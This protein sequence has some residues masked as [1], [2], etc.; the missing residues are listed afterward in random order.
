[1]AA[2][3][4]TFVDTNVLVYAHD[5]SE[6]VKQPLA[7]ALLEELWTTRTGALSTQVLQEFYVVATRKFD[8]PMSREE[9]REVV[10][11]YA[12]WPL[13]LVDLPLIL[14][15][16]NLEERHRLSFWDALIIEAAT[17][18]GAARVVTEDLQGGRVIDGVRIE[19]PFP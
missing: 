4:L 2:H 12:A 18:A 7:R 5:G 13:V 17:R 9:A 16:S 10:A 14:T 3:E 6:T 15:A 11:L 1:M 19:N 8:P